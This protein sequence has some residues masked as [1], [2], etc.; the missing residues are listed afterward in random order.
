M[1]ATYNLSNNINHGSFASAPFYPLFGYLNQIESSGT[2]NP[3][4]SGF[5]T[6]RGFANVVN[7]EC[8]TTSLENLMAYYNDICAAHNWVSSPSGL[9][10]QTSG[11]FDVGH[12]G[13][14]FY[15]TR[16]DL[17]R[18]KFTPEYSGTH[19]LG[20]PTLI[21]N[22]WT[23]FMDYKRFGHQVTNMDQFS[24]YQSFDPI[25]ISGF[26]NIG[27]GTSYQPR[28]PHN[29]YPDS[30]LGCGSFKGSSQWYTGTITKF[31]GGS[32]GDG[33][34][35]SVEQI[36]GFMNVISNNFA[37]GLSPTF[38]LITPGYY[39]T[40]N[41]IGRGAAVIVNGFTG[42]NYS[43]PFTTDI[44]ISLLYI[45]GNTLRNV[46]G[47]ENITNFVQNN[48]PVSTIGISLGTNY[49]LST[50]TPETLIPF[51]GSGT[52]LIYGFHN[53]PAKDIFSAMTT[54]FL[55][56]QSGIY[57]PL[58]SLNNILDVIPP[59]GSKYLFIANIPTP[60]NLNST[61]LVNEFGSGN[62]LNN[63]FFSGICYGQQTY[64]YGSQPSEYNDIWFGGENIVSTI[65]GSFG[66]SRQ[67]NFVL[68]TGVIRFPNHNISGYL[69][70]ILPM[71]MMTAT[72]SN[73]PFSDV[74]TN[75]EM[76]GLLNYYPFFSGSQVWQTPSG[77][78]F[79]GEF[80]GS[81]PSGYNLLAD[82]RSI[83]ASGF[84]SF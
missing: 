78:F 19:L 20:Y 25:A 58:T 74:G 1:A 4:P 73:T 36:I 80:N 57:S 10:P 46:T 49:L 17:T 50:S 64:F 3:W 82:N 70:T 12:S 55:Q 33:Q 41:I 63:I 42:T 81:P 67:Y 24:A 15:R 40:S 22:F 84:E 8:P 60:F 59:S 18:E 7:Q 29:F 65:G 56:I 31:D 9:L 79:Y 62:V 16:G 23:R 27:S 53:N 5:S 6:Q 75:A 14:N 47:I 52:E 44:P 54:A 71:C 30:Y 45:D 69:H 13:F 21:K 76:F 61:I 68:E 32:F 43:I 77:T 28:V 35:K 48:L 38:F 2:N 37:S 11:F 39:R 51:Q 66:D 26:F 34:P 72:Q 83:L